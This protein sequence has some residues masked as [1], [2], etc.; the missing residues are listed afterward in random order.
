MSSRSL[1]LSLFLPPFHLVATQNILFGCALQIRSAVNCKGLPEYMHS[2]HAMAAL[3]G[4]N[5]NQSS[6]PSLFTHAS[7]RNVETPNFFFCQSCMNGAEETACFQGD[8]ERFHSVGAVCR[9]W[10]RRLQHRICAREQWSGLAALEH[11][12]RIHAAAVAAESVNGQEVPTSTFRGL[13]SG[14][15]VRTFSVPKRPI[16]DLDEEQTYADQRGIVMC[17]CG[18]LAL[19]FGSQPPIVPQSLEQRHAAAADLAEQTRVACVAGVVLP[20]S[21]PAPVL[22]HGA[23]PMYIF[24]AVKMLQEQWRLRRLRKLIC[25]VPLFNIY[26]RARRALFHRLVLAAAGTAARRS[27][28]HSKALTKLPY[29]I[30]AEHEYCLEGF[31]TRAV[32]LCANDVMDFIE[33]L[34]ALVAFAAAHPDKMIACGSLRS[35]IPSA[36][37]TRLAATTPLSRRD[38]A[39]LVSDFTTAFQPLFNLLGC[40]SFAWAEPN[41]SKR[42]AGDTSLDG[43]DD[44]ATES[45]SGAAADA[46][47]AA[48]TNA[49]RKAARHVTESRSNHD[50]LVTSGTPRLIAAARASEEMEP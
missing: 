5:E 9:Q 2:K 36:L 48:P 37:L 50:E 21:P 13:V 10:F 34:P 26:P 43:V 32:A 46:A 35:A 19:H 31:A 47:P 20:V 4:K 6:A 29:L 14:M 11:I 49:R 8:G 45:G 12:P 7:I 27:A 30:D 23:V 17:N 42:K 24:G 1:F 3:A 28:A 18:A 40:T 16:R 25:K 39:E 33:T 44:N 15:F 22:A 41:P 38:A